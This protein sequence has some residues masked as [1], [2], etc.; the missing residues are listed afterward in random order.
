MLAYHERAG[1]RIGE[2]TRDFAM[3]RGV[4]MSAAER[5]EQHRLTSTPP[6]PARTGRWRSEMSAEDLAA[7][8]G[9][10]RQLLRELGYE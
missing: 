4:K 7:F 6:T 9:E 1:R 5:A 3:R 2:F 10:P 8:E